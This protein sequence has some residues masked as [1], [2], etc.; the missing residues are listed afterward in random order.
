VESDFGYHIIQLTDIRAPKQRSFEEMRAELEADVINQQAPAKFAD[1]ADA[2]TNGVYEQADSLKPVADRLKLN[3]QTASLSRTPALGAKGVLANAKFLNA[4]FSS[5]SIEKKRNTEAI[6][7]AP[8]QL[9]SGRITHYAAAHTLPF[10]EVKDQVRVRVV[11]AR[12]TELAQ[13]EGK[14]KLAAWK[15]NSGAAVL[16]APLVVSREDAQQQPSQLVAAVLRAD[17]A[18]LPTWVGADLGAQ[19]YAIAKINKLIPRDAPVE[20]LRKQGREQYGQGWAAAES[21]AYY[22]TLKE[23]FKVKINIAKPMAKTGF[24]AG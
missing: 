21:R 24:D 4:I 15:S 10:V 11:T 5:D 17:L 8:N 13:K 22:N 16:S 9:V 18:N 12:A 23:R 6:E 3:V 1:A 19:G 14:E 20:A 2:F 7:T